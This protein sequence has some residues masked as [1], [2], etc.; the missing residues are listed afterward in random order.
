MEYLLQEFNPEIV[1]VIEI[2]DNSKVNDDDDDEY[3]GNSNGIN[4]DS[5]M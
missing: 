2:D 3:E 5:I 1:K 4:D